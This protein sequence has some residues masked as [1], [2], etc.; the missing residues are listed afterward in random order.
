MGHVRGH[1]TQECRLKIG[2]KK[3]RAL[4]TNLVFHW[5][6]CHRA[7]TTFCKQEVLQWINTNGL[8]KQH[9][10][11]RKLCQQSPKILFCKNSSRSSSSNSS[12]VCWKILCDNL[13]C[14]KYVL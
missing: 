3:T 2:S 5:Q 14:N 9:L 1:S 4:N 10:K 13:R 7:K 11:F 12:M 8:Q 6:T